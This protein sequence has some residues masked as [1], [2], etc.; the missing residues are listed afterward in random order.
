MFSRKLLTRGPT[1]PSPDNLRYVEKILERAQGKSRE[2][3]A[4]GDEHWPGSKNTN[5]LGLFTF[6]IHK[7]LTENELEVIDFENLIFDENIIFPISK[8]AG[9]K[10]FGGRLKTPKKG[11]GQYVIAKTIPLP[12]VN[13]VESVVS[14]A[15]GYPGED[16]T[17]TAKTS[18][19]AADVFIEINGRK[20][21]MK[22]RGK[23]WTYAAKFDKLGKIPFKV[24][25]TNENDV[26][27]KMQSGE[28]NVIKKRAEIANVVS[29]TVQPTQGKQG[30]KY[31]FKVTTDTPAKEVAI[32]I[33]GKPF[34]MTGSGTNWTLAQTIDD[35][36]KVDFSA[37]AT[38]A[39]GV[40]GTSKGG[41]LRITAAPVKIVAVRTSP[42]TGF[43]GEEFSITVSTNIPAK[44][45]SLN[46]DGTDYPM[47]GS[48]KKWQFKKTIPEIGTKSFTVAA[49]NV[50][51]VIG[52]KRTGQ[53]ITKKSPLPIPDVASAD[54]GV[55]SPGKGYAGDRFE[56]KVKTTAPSDK[57]FVE[58]EGKRFPMKGSGANWN[59]TAKIDKL[60][61]SIYRVQAINKDGAQGKTREGTITTRKRPAIPI[62][63]VKAAVSPK[64]GHSARPFNFSVTTDRPADGVIVTIGKTR[65]KMTGKG[66]RWQ[67]SQKIARS[68]RLAYTIAALDKEGNPGRPNKGTLTVYKNR[69]RANKDG[70]LTD[71]ISGKKTIRFKDNGDGTVTDLMT[72]LMW[73]HTPKQIA[74]AYNDAVEY[75]KNLK[76]N[77][78]G[79][80]RLPTIGELN[81]LA[82]KKRQNPALPAGNPFTNVVTH[83]SYWSKTKHKFGPQYVYQ[84]S[85][86]YGKAN[87]QKKTDNAIVWPVRYAELPEG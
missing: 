77:G 53:I 28:I 71:L 50:E 44:S 34:K 11:R 85:M 47:E 3:I 86:W 35:A 79:G 29:A 16:F 46:M 17:F 65:Y 54:V 75:C 64:K 67:L 45:V 59:Y 37:T 60:G 76:V 49:L 78:Q 39:D 55:V 31:Q 8:I 36:G 42:K 81:K 70:S 18:E 74:V 20:N 68:G 40:Q 24:F 62:N 58:I 21:A 66:T 10:L 61:T 80:W 2:V 27:G 13:V 72:S 84:M 57:V 6:Y 73:L 1:P 43:A 30:D 33:K 22:G 41:D 87:H 26:S 15:K 12:I 56:L 9:A 19:P 63:I 69:Y 32:H 83:V 48:D 51:G 4:L 25:A 7:A 23:E 82:D 14:P 5:G 52:P 38:N